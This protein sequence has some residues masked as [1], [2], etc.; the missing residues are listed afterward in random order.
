MHYQ[1]G[2]FLHSNS[3]ANPLLHQRGKPRQLCRVPTNKAFEVKFPKT[4]AD[5]VGVAVHANPGNGELTHSVVKTAK[6][7]SGRIPVKWL[8]TG[9]KLIVAATAE[10]KAIGY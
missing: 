6:A 2:N 3:H 7:P 9:R 1:T 10:I 8:R 4:H 5:G